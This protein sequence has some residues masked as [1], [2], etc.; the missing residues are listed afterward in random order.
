MTSRPSVLIIAGS[1]SSGGAGLLRDAQVLTEFEVDVRCAVTAITAQTNQQVVSVHCVPPQLIREQIT[2]ALQ[3]G[4][5]GAIKIGMLG[6]RAAINAV[7]ESLPARDRIP[8]VL[9]PVLASSS[10][11]SLLEESGLAALREWL[12]PRVTLITPNLPEAAALLEDRIAA[13]EAAMLD[14]AQRLLGLGV[15][16]VLMKGG[17]GTGEESVDVLVTPCAAPKFMRV[18]RVTAT[19][20]GTGCALSSAIAAGLVLKMPLADAC[21]RAKRYVWDK[22][23]SDSVRDR[24]ASSRNLRT[25]GPAP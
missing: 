25:Y 1:D 22:L 12:I 24:A 14:Q 7:A 2:A 8:I 23:K 5:I 18:A 19:L 6:S 17:H 21:D 9:D 10:G 20:R 16:A 3:S 11:G 15:Q 4:G 13:S